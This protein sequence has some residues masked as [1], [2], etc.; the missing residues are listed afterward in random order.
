[1]HAFGCPELIAL[2]HDIFECIAI[3]YGSNQTE[4]RSLQQKVSRLR[5]SS[6]IFDLKHMTRE[7]EQAYEAMWD[8]YTKNGPAKHITN[9]EC[10]K[11][12]NVAAFNRLQND[13]DQ[14]R[15]KNGLQ[16]Q[17]LNG[18]VCYIISNIID[19]R[20]IKSNSFSEV[21]QQLQGKIGETQDLHHQINLL[22]AQVNELQNAIPVEPHELPH[23]VPDPVPHPVPDPAQLDPNNPND[24][25]AIA[26]QFQQALILQRAV[27]KRK[28]L[29][30]IAFYNQNR[31]TTNFR[32]IQAEFAIAPSSFKKYIDEYNL[33][34]DV[35]VH[36]KINE[37]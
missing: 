24:E 13:N 20:K 14:L 6:P 16:T 7:L 37:E 9:I 25:Q 22:Q 21:K 10:D 35:K 3:F 36:F 5:L 29:E 26:N 2:N 11:E 28:I 19:T 34:G 27:K 12:I 33:T 8:N 31:N 23:P 32:F 17:E 15:I 1:M 18:I 30:A 4:L